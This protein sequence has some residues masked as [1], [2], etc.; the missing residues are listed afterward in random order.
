M[1]PDDVSMNYV[2]CLVVLL[3]FLVSFG[4]VWVIFFSL[5][6]T[7]FKLSKQ[8]DKSR[9]GTIIVVAKTRENTKVWTDT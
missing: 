5:E 6:N 3:T 7:K 9:E 4:L 2:R 8:V 1:L